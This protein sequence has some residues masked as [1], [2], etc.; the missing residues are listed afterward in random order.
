MKLKF[1]HEWTRDEDRRRSL[2]HTTIDLGAGRMLD[3]SA[4]VG[5]RLGE[6]KVRELVERHNELV[7]TRQIYDLP[8]AE[9]LEA[10]AELMRVVSP[11]DYQWFEAARRNLMELA[12]Q[13]PKRTGE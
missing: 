11:V 5:C 9:F 8:R 2:C 4:W 7:L 1:K 3:D 6:A 13:L 10:L 12:E